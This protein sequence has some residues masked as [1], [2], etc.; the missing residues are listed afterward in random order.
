MR[1]LRR[2]FIRII[3]LMSEPG[4]FTESGQ[5]IYRHEDPRKEFEP[6]C[7]DSENIEVISAHIHEYLGSTPGV[8]HE[9][10][11]HLVHID[12]HIVPP[13]EERPFYS[14]VTSGMSDRPMT[15]PEGF[16][17]CRF[18]G[19]MICLPADWP[20]TPD[21][22]KD[23][24]Y[25]WPMRHLKFLARMPNK[26][27]KW[28]GLD[29]TIPNGDPPEATGTSNFCCALIGPASTAPEA[30]WHLKINEEK[31]IIFYGVH[32]I[33]REE[34]DLKMKKGAQA[35]WE[36]LEKNGVTEFLDVNRKNVAKKRFGIF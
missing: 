12:L 27:D 6:A 15:T 11:S 5:P 23:E 2:A 31:I 32:L 34:M 21:D 16:E 26:Y 24:R 33:Y 35:L 17:K 4:E 19:L 36:L 22:W 28:L 14:L 29:H 10:I 25:W 3:N 18:A 7:G 9:L 1:V 20:M 8:C 13:S 30:F